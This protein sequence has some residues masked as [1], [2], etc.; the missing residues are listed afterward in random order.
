MNSADEKME[1]QRLP[2]GQRTSQVEGQDSNQ[3]CLHANSVS[4]L[5]HIHMRRGF[6]IQDMASGC[7]IM[8]NQD[9]DWSWLFTIYTGLHWGDGEGSGNPLQSSCLENPMDGGA[10]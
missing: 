7:S 3:T 8:V 4:L 1:I 9:A 5:L 2:S 10:W 6:C